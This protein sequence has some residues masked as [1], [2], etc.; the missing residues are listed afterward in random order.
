[1]EIQPIKTPL[2]RHG[3]SLVDALIANAQIEEGDIIAV[4]SKVLATIEGAAIN[5]AQVD[6]TK[7]ATKL[8][9]QL[10]REETEIPFL[11]AVIDE[12][13]RMHGKVLPSCTHA[14]LTELKP[15]GLEQG[16]LLV[17]NAGLDRSNIE[18]GFA[19]GWPRDPL[20]RA[21]QLRQELRERTEKHVAV[22]V[23]DS[24]CRPRRQGVTAI[25]LTVSGFEPFHSHIG[26][27]DLFSRTMR[28]T[29]EASADQLA[30]AANAIMGNADESVPAAIIRDHG[31]TLSGHEGWVD[32][33]APEDDLFQF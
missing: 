26:R 33:I 30:T 28:V 12:T 31:L 2:L 23:T 4:S 17:P 25:A 19:I 8:A 1:M 13:H 5:L 24:A 27:S 16:V 20:K 14:V 6:I 15:D 18:E 22:L 11:Q 29:Q 10:K 21:S 3:D 9:K 32:G 7:E